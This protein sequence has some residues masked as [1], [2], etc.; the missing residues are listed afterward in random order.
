MRR[1]E[2]FVI[3]DPDISQEEREPV[4]ERVKELITQQEGFLVFED[5]WGE[6]KLAYQI[7]K[8]ERGHYVRF[9]YCGLAPLVNE[10]ERF[11]RIDDRALKYMTV[12]LDKDV[13]LEKVKEE[14]AAAESQREAELAA[15]ETPE[16]TESAELQQEEVAAAEEEKK[17]ITEQEPQ[18]AEAVQDP[19]VAE[20]VQDPQVAEAVQ[21]PQV[22]EAVQEPQV[23]EEVQASD[24]TDSAEKT[25]PAEKKEEA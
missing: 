19:Q 25:T 9:D 18:V 8:K 1:Y 3:T 4:F 15:Q 24:S 10:I 22:A 17:E 23:E 12:V 13:D 6:R 2:T 16:E 11:F 5:V 20:A 14:K 21:E 7:K